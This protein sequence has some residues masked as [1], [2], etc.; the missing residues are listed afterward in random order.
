[1][2]LK[3]QGRTTTGA[4]NAAQLDSSSQQAAS[5]VVSASAQSMLPLLDRLNSF[6]GKALQL[7]TQEMV[8]NAKERAVVD[9][10]NGEFDLTEDMSIYGM[11]YDGA[12]KTA[13]ISDTTTSI[14]AAVERVAALNKY[15][16]DGFAK[17]WKAQE[18]QFKKS[19]K[20]V[21]E[22]GYIEAVVGDVAEQYGNAAYTKIASAFTTAQ[23]NLQVKENEESLVLLENEYT[24]AMVSGD[25]N[26]IGASLQSMRATLASMYKTNQ[27]GQQGIE[28]R[29]KL[30]GKSVRKAVVKNEFAKEMGAGKGSQYITSFRKKAKS[31]ANF[32]DATPTEINEMMDDMYSTI[33]KKHSFED[34]A[35]ARNEAYKSRQSERL[36]KDLNSAWIAGTLEPQD[37]DT[38][39]ESG[40]I[41]IQEHSLY[42]KKV[43]DT[44]ANFT[45]TGT[46]LYIVQ[47]LGS[48]SKEEISMFTDVTNEDKMKYMRQL[49]IYQTSES[50]K[51]TATVQG[52]ASL[53][54]LKN[55][56]N[57][58]QAG[59]LAGLTKQ[60]DL[61]AYNKAYQAF[62][63]EMED[64]KPEQRESR[65]MHYA[66][67]VLDTLDRA[68]LEHKKDVSAVKQQKKVASL[69]Q[70]V[71]SYQRNIGQ[72]KSEYYQR[73][74]AEF[75]DRFGTTGDI[76]FN[77]VNWSR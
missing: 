34:A 14:K 48:L 69:Q 17:A 39:L 8:K 2:Q 74:L 23:H 4:L 66:Q 37:V 30:L 36:K 9:V 67:A 45:D 40:L 77:K 64:L 26:A 72:T 70:R 24:A 6:S 1:M 46:E 33:S 13:F 56:F 55:R 44:G 49:E 28:S 68:K 22:N 57:I 63:L 3:R 53:T 38:A 18:S 59:M 47:N 5:K 19:S 41:S 10:K 43:F 73:G 12:A 76:K 35:I 52:R 16:P 75:A 50:G 27:I 65:S 61:D 60:K 20:Q 58:T 32:K 25:E 54:L 7:G 62:I 31:H 21:D 51:W 42:S 15:S 71:N 29:W 11:A